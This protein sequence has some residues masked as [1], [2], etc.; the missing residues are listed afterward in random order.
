MLFMDPFSRIPHT[1]RSASRNTCFKNWSAD[2]QVAGR[3]SYASQLLD[4]MS[5]RKQQKS[6]CT[7]LWDV[8]KIVQSVVSEPNVGN[9]ALVHALAVKQGALADLC[10]ATSLLTVY[11][12]CKE[13]GSAV[14]LFGEVLDRD[15]VFWNA[16]MS[17]CVE[18]RS[19][20]LQLVSS[21]RWSA[22]GKGVHGLSV[23][24]GMLSDTV[25]SNALINIMYEF[26]RVWCWL[27]NPWTGNQIGLWGEHHISVANSLISF[28]SQFRDIHATETVF[29]GMVVKNVVSWN[30][31]IKGFFLNE[32]AEEAFYLLRAMQ[33]VA[34]IQPDIATVVTIIPFCAELLLL[35]EG[36]AAHG[37]TIRREM[38]SELSVINS[39][40]NMYS[41]CNNLKEAEY[42]FLTMPKKDVVAWNTMIF[43]YAQN[44]QSQE[45]QTLF[46][47]MLGCYS[48]CTLPTL[49]AITPSWESLLRLMLLVGTLLLLAALRKDSFWEALE[50]FDLFRKASQ[51]HANPII[52]CQCSISLWQSWVNISRKVNSWSCF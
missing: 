39:L 41:K 26:A 29:K 27:G 17:A 15:V 34:S 50:Y 4:E 5:E 51:F 3:F 16:M 11:S 12:R 1:C 52:V 36:K 22:R 44:G 48:T 30:A 24:A 21:R 32:Q 25:L 13:F 33:F 40:I 2:S 6:E 7:L 20:K 8:F 38:A 46:K 9:A 42:L 10:T 23:K 37:F 49:L 43:G 35:R 19:F 14:A 47:N 28:Y 45:A 31:M 18:N